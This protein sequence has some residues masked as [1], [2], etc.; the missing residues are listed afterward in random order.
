MENGRKNPANRGN[1]ERA[2]EPK[3]SHGCAIVRTH[4]MDCERACVYVM[5]HATDDVPSHVPTCR[6]RHAAR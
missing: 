1:N 2:R 6:S 4:E 5:S 3:C